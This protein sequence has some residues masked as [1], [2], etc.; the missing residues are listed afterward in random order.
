MLFQ[1]YSWIFA[2]GQTVATVLISTSA[3]AL[4]VATGLAFAGLLPW[5]VLPV[6]FGGVPV[7]WAGQ[8]FQIG[9]TVLMLLLA[10]YV[11]TSRQVLMLE[12]THRDFAIGMDDVTRA[13][14]A[15]HAADRKGMFEMQREFDAV[16]ERFQHLKSHPDLPE[17]D[18]EL[19]TIAAQMSQQSRE[20]AQVFSDEKVA[21]A[22]ESLHQRRRDADELQDRIQSAHAAIRD[23][24]RQ[25]DDVEVEEASVE[26][27][28]GRLREDFSAL[29]S[30]IAGRHGKKNGR[31]LRP[32]SDAS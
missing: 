2:A 19:L 11:P 1:R 4:L 15:A 21:R 12:A 31:H 23:I 20:L 30:R 28:L 16:R 8:A 18:A 9:L 27:Q 25:L 14:Q 24:R 3:A 13:Y 10:A 22:T 5:L 26:A 29:E 17:I 32:V 6:S 7:D